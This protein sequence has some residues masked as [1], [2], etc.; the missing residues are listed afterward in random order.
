MSRYSYIA[1][2]F[3][4]ACGYST[5]KKS[6]K[7]NVVKFSIEIVIIVC[8]GGSNEWDDFRMLWEI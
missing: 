4:E 7:R 2:L 8:T 6:F 1:F 3:I 5:L